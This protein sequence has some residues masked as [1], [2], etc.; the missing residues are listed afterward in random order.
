[1]DRLIGNLVHLLIYEMFG[2]KGEMALKT[3]TIRIEML[4][5]TTFGENTFFFGIWV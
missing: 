2:P 4:G 3:G 1:M 5:I